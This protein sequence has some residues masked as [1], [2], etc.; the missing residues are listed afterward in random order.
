MQHRRPRADRGKS[1]VRS[2]TL[3]ILFSTIALCLLAFPATVQVA[4]EAIVNFADVRQRID[5]FGASDTWVGPLS[6]AQADLFFSPTNGIGLSI[7]RQ[8]IDWSGNSLSTPANATKAAARGAIV[9]AAPW[10]APA[11]W[12]DNGSTSNGGH[13][14]PQYYDAWATRLANYAVASQQTSGVPLYAI[15]AQNEPD[16][17]AGYDSMIYTN[18]EMT[19]FVKVLGPKLAALNPRPKLMQPEVSSWGNAWGFSS[20]ALADS[21]AAQYFD[22]LG[23]HQYAGLTAPQSTARPIWETEQSSFEP[24]DPGIL[25]GIGVARW[26]HD[27]L[28]TGGVSAWHYWWLVGLNA[29]D[30]GLI[31]YNRNT[32]I[33]K[34]LYTVGNYSKF[35]RP[36]YVMVGVS[37]GTPNVSV[38]AFKNP[39][40]GAFVIVAINQNGTDAPQTVVM[41]GLSSTSVTP[42]VTSSTL[43]LAQQANLTVVNGS[44]TTM[45]PG[46]SVTTFV[47]NGTAPPPPPDTTAPSVPSGLAAAAVS[48]SQV[49]LT[50]TASTDN[51]AVSGYRIYRG[52]AQIG[53]SGSPS[54]SDTSVAPSTTYTYAVAAYDAAGNVSGLSGN[55]SATTPSGPVGKPGMP[56]AQSPANGA[57]GVGTTPILSWSSSGATAYYVGLGMSSPPG[58]VSANQTATTYNPGT[59]QANKTYYWQV[60][61][62]NASGAT[63]GPIWSFTTGTTIAPPSAPSGVKIIK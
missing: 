39:S 38:S 44:F 55:A 16:Y 32:Q 12:K 15:S 30:E 13:L 21:T 11:A 18:Q 41:S 60:T 17:V 59:L 8:G 19:N 33:T 46:Y 35:V 50:W 40:T 54:Y 20:S 49:N 57:T 43:D 51:V 14:L 45:L 1:R 5:G 37:G 62:V 29:D 31:G 56:V 2:L 23:L 58:Q 61:A 6:D 25:N 53:T 26:I 28:V 48:S 63:A 34:R 4:G 22:I 36:G 24:F 27:A 42:W 7:L 9:W 3:P 47:S 10:T 52:G